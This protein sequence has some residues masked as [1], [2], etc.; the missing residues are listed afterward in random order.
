MENPLKDL[1]NDPIAENPMKDP[2][3]HSRR[4]FLFKIA[5]LLNGAVGA[6]LA[7][8]VFGYL[9]GPFFKKNSELQQLGS[10]RKS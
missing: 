6:V 8:P 7:V 3:E 9:F 10:S 1:I 4:K 2:S 5:L